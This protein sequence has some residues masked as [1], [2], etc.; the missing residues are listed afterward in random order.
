MKQ[1]PHLVGYD[2]DF[3]GDET[4]TQPDGQNTLTELMYAFR[5]I[6]PAAVLIG[7]MAIGI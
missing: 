7:F 6:S 3:E 1:L 5:F 2:A 4:F